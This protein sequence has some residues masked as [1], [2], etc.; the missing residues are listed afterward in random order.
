MELTLCNTG[1]VQRADVTAVNETPIRPI[2]ITIVTRDTLNDCY[3]FRARVNLDQLSDHF[4]RGIN[5]FTVTMGEA[6][7][8]VILNVEM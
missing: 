5:R 8:N 7:A 2:L 1:F 6:E 4:S 3:L